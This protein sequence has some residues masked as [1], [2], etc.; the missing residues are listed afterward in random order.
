VINS[1]DRRRYLF[2][3]FTA[4]LDRDLRGGAE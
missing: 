2:E 1:L 3:V 4:Q